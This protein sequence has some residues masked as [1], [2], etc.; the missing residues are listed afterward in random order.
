MRKFKRF[1]PRFFRRSS[2]PVVTQAEFTRIPGSLA[3]AHS[4][5]EIDIR[6]AGAIRHDPLAV[7]VIPPSNEESTT[8]QAQQSQRPPSAP[9]SV[10][11]H[12]S[13]ANGSGVTF[14]GS[15]VGKYRILTTSKSLAPFNKLRWP[16]IL[17]KVGLL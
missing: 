17:I 15:L 2:P 5:S 9:N 14:R 10:S 13:S 3:L 1:I 11:N 4:R 7:V 12:P 6:L 8:Y 16:M